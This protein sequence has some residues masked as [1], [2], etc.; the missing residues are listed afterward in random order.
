MLRGGRVL[1]TFRMHCTSWWIWLISI[2]SSVYYCL[3]LYQCGLLCWMGTRV[4][5][6]FVSQTPFKSRRPDHRLTLSVIIL[7]LFLCVA[8]MSQ[9]W[10]LMVTWWGSLACNFIISV[11]RRAQPC[12]NRT[13][14]L[15]ES[16]ARCSIWTIYVSVTS[17]WTWLR[18]WLS[19]Q[20]VYVTF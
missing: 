9:S 4:N 18:C 19:K 14:L 20:H 5:G 12:K 1:D 11:S 2:V 8:D 17:M 16:S 10:L 15:S 6:S 7:V 3:L 13:A